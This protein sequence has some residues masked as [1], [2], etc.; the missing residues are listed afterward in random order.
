M[1]FERF[2][3]IRGEVDGL[4][5]QRWDFWLNDLNLVLNDYITE[6]RETKRHGWKTAKFFDRLD[7]RSSNIE[8]AA[9][10]LPPDV[11]SDVLEQ[12]RSKLTVVREP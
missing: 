5:Q 11:V 3:V 7:R 4:S 2:T 9:V 8:Q 12:V 1:A 6:K 10:P